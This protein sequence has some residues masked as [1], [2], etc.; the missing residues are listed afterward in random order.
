M[1]LLQNHHFLASRRLGA[2]RGPR[3][4][5]DVP[6]IGA[7][8]I[9]KIQSDDLILLLGDFPEAAHQRRV[10]GVPAPPFGSLLVL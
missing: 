1:D 10:S 2:R 3:A 6:A 4:L 8:A 9:L 5:S 7:G